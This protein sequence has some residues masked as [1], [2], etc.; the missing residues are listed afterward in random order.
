[1]SSGKSFTAERDLRKGVNSE[2]TCMYLEHP[3]TDTPFGMPTRE[4]NIEAI[5]TRAQIPQLFASAR[6]EHSTLQPRLA[7]AADD[8]WTLEVGYQGSQLWRQTRG[9]QC[10]CYSR[11]GYG[12]T[13]T[14]MRMASKATLRLALLDLYYVKSVIIYSLVL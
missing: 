7:F 12:Y 13:W 5:M 2:A 10:V 11:Y 4:L 1:M 8:V 3:T 14:V 9:T 6:C